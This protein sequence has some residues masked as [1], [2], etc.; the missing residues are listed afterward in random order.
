MLALI[1]FIIIMVLYIRAEYRR[2]FRRLERK[3]KRE[4]RRQLR[5][6]RMI[7]LADILLGET[8]GRLPVR[9]P[10]EVITERIVERKTV[11]IPTNEYAD[12]LQW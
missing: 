5:I 10:Y 1:W 6:K 7:Q 11:R 12:W 9:E 3:R 8:Q 2:W 4:L